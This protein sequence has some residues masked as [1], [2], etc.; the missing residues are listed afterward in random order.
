MTLNE[1]LIKAK[2]DALGLVN[3]ANALFNYLC[4]LIDTSDDAPEQE[5]A[6]DLKDYT[7]T[8][9]DNFDNLDSWYFFNGPHR[10][11]IN[12]SNQARVINNQLVM[13]AIPK[14]DAKPECSY[15]RTWDDQDLSRITKN[16][17]GV[18]IID[19]EN[20]ETYIEASISFENFNETQ[21]VWFAFWLFPP[22]NIKEDG[23]LW[24]KNGPRTN[25]YDKNPQTGNEV[26]IIEYVP[27]HPKYNKTTRKN[28]FNTAIY[29]ALGDKRYAK[30]PGHNSYGFFTD[31]NDFIKHPVDVARGFHKYAIY[32]SEDSYKFYIDDQLFWQTNDIKFINSKKANGIVLSYEIDSGLW[33]ESGPSFNEIGIPSTTI[34]DYVKVYQK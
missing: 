23:S 24:Q 2:D 15:I 10:D 19:P 11:A 29:T 1:K 14:P 27:W 8:W 12:T 32:I 18:Y 17:P 7:I 34:I 6:P 28:G 26:D 13:T 30:R 33:A 3:Q 31:I 4:Q 9:Q 16:D 21:G 25:A 22:N 20:K 5:Y